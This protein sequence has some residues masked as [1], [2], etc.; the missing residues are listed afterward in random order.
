MSGQNYHQALRKI[1][2]RA[3]EAILEVYY[4]AGEMEIQSKD[5]DSPLTLA[6]QRAHQIILEGLTAIDGTI[7]VLS[8]ESELKSYTERKHWQ[9]YWLVDPLDGTKEF[10]GR[11]GEFTVNVALIEQG[12]P[13]AGWVYV[14]VESVLYYGWAGSQSVACKE[15]KGKISAITTRALNRSAPLDVVASRRH[16]GEEL[17]VMLEKAKASFPEVQLNSYGSSLKICMVAEGL[18]DWY[19]RLAPTSEWDTAAAHAILLAAGGALIDDLLNPLVYNQKE[20]IL[21]PFFHALGDRVELRCNRE[22]WL[23]LLVLN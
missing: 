20:S 23:D 6:D 16:G 2:Q 17:G 7:P 13:I 21:N 8:E 9:R 3:G 14:P 1:L 19:P 12:E 15:Q 22:F 10:I 4:E 18:A 11:N 5:D